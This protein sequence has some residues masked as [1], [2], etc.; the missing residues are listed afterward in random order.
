MAEISEPRGAG[1]Q[2]KAAHDL[3]WRELTQALAARCVSEQAAERIATL[4]PADSLAEARA[5]M[6]LSAEALQALRLGQPVPGEA[7]PVIDE[8]IEH[9]RRQGVIDAEQL[10]A[11]ART[12]SVA[13]RLRS[14]AR[15][16]GQELGLLAAALT[17]PPQ[18]DALREELDAAIDE[19]GLVRDGASPELRQARRRL[20]GARKSLMDTLGR[21]ASHHAD[22]LREGGWV[23]RDGRY[24]LPVRA[25]AHRRVDGIVVG[26]SATGATL[27]VEPP[28]VTR[29]CNKLTLAEAEVGREVARIVAELS[30]RVAA[31]V[32]DVA[33]A[34]EACIVA[35]FLA[36]LSRWAEVGRCKAVELEDEAVVDLRSVRHP[37]LVLQGGPVVPSDLRLHAGQALV[38]SGPNAGGKTVALKC[39]GLAVWMAR[40]G[41]PLPVGEESRL[42]WFGQVL[43]DIGDDQSIERSLSTFSAH[44]ANL[45]R[46]LDR[47]DDRTLVLLD[48][49]AG[50]TDPD[51][52]SALAA[53]TLESLVERGAAVAAT[54]HYER[55]KE[56][57]H[58]DVRFV[59]AS[60][61]FDF[62]AMQPTFAL[63]MGVPGAS[64]ALAVA[65]RFGMPA[66]VVARARALLPQAAVDRERL[67]ADIERERRQLAEA[68]QRAVDDAEAAE[69]LLREAE[70]ERQD[71]R[72]K[73]RDKLT[74]ETA[75]LVSQVRVARAELRE[76]SSKVKSEQL[77]PR[78]AERTVAEAA[79][80]VAVGAPLERATRSADKLAAGELSLSEIVVGARV[81]VERLGTVAEVAEAPER[82]QVLVRAGAF[83]LRVPLAEL[84]RPVHGRPPAAA[85][86]RSER[87]PTQSASRL[88]GD[89]L[90]ERALRTSSNTCNL[91]GKR[92]DEA[93]FDLDRFLDGL[94]RTSEP[95]G[96]VLHGHGTGALKQAV[97]EHL[98]LSR[99][100]RDVRPAE[101]EEGGDAFTVFRL[102][103]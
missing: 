2:A 37:L 61:G 96:F 24:G 77:S 68:R 99:L 49:V 101:Q 14:Y 3:Q 52:G 20:S 51:E 63:T 88:V 98:A 25:D 83:S 15:D 7:A 11:V 6:A 47:S 16:R 54:T 28:E 64:S 42:G 36:A 70:Q 5:R 13:K 50:G 53:A 92:V 26:T 9:L 62:D 100:V 27:Y 46:I 30:A 76:L 75:A 34:Y 58:D 44:V 94:M 86:A 65:G 22:V 103:D 8:A 89:V 21:L 38:I 81:F 82:G 85:T 84:R 78:Q 17:S 23:E 66:A 12:L 32:D 91:R 59:N 72:R 56:L 43:T 102:V 79:R 39:L 57:A 90:A 74:R 29:L 69:A 10:H 35:D 87:A 33:I 40:S 18:L 93:L 55:L 95:V 41:I 31:E 71:V 48:E 80:L 45:S 19:L 4:E 97:R 67:L 1:D 60:V 73:E